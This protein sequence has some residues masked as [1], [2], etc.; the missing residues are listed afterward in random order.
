MSRIVQSEEI[1]LKEAFYKNKIE[2]CNKLNEIINIIPK[3]TCVMCLI[4]PPI[5]RPPRFFSTKIAD[6]ML[7]KY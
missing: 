5:I 2:I 7:Y 3:P 4:C 1:I 6:K